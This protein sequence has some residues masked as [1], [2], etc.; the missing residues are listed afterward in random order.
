MEGMQSEPPSKKIEKAT[1]SK[2]PGSPRMSDA[3]K[4]NSTATKKNK[5][6]SN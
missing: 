2:V 5:N 3:E 6:K 4:R 1:E